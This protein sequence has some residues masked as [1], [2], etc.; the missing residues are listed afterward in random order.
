M[1]EALVFSCR[2]VT[3]IPVSINWMHDLT[4]SPKQLLCPAAKDDL[5]PTKRR[6]KITHSKFGA[7]LNP[8]ASFLPFLLQKEKTSR[9]PSLRFVFI[10]SFSPPPQKKKARCPLFPAFAAAAEDHTKAKCRFLCTFNEVILYVGAASE[11][12]GSELREGRPMINYPLLLRGRETRN[13]LHTTRAFPK[14]KA[15]RWEQ[16]WVRSGEAEE[17]E[18]T[19]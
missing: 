19:Q 6:E 16:Y 13:E 3:F 4:F 8:A 5:F 10:R 9:Y 2:D 17:E 15:T 11:R 1:R 14:K 12:I 18:D 7:K